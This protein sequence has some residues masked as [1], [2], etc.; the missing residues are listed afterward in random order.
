MKRFTQTYAEAAKANTER[1]Q[2]LEASCDMALK[3][4]S[5]NVKKV[6]NINE[7][8]QKVI[9]KNVLKVRSSQENI[10]PYCMA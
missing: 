2:H 3:E 6:I 7:S 10:M 1:I 5:Q 8:A 4:T 9:A